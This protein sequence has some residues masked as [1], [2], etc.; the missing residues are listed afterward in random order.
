MYN[1]FHNCVNHQEI[2]QDFHLALCLVVVLDDRLGQEGNWSLAE[3]P[4][5]TCLIT[6]LKI[7]G[8]KCFFPY[9]DQYNPAG[10]LPADP[11]Q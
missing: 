4:R 6:I 7:G 11:E 5:E 1:N 8:H 10:T 3:T 2:N 9:L